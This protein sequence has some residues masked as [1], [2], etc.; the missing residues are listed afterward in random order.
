M[1]RLAGLDAVLLE[2]WRQLSLAPKDKAHAWNTPVLATRDGDGV[3][4]RSVILREAREA[5]SELMVYTDLRSGK[6]RQLREHPLGVL[7]MWS[8]ALSWQVRCQVRLDVETSGLDV[9]SR[10]AQL[11]LSPAAQDYLSPLPPGAVLGEAPP[12]GAADLGLGK[13]AFFGVITA[14]VQSIDWLELGRQ[15]HRR[16]RFDAQGARWLQ[17]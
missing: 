14:Q 8:P 12:P 5:E 17:P 10:W 7:V 16:A 4:A 11:K 15:G 3:D 13:Q 9:T 1:E 6:V 2:I